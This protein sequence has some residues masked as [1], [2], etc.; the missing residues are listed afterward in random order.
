MEACR[1]DDELRLEIESLLEPS[2]PADPVPKDASPEPGAAPATG[3]SPLLTAGMRIGPYQIENKLG[4]GGMGEVYRARDVRLARYVAIKVLRHEIADTAARR[5]RFES[6]ARAVA[7]LTHPN[8]V[9]I[10]DFGELNGKPYAVSELIEGQSLRALLRRGPLAVRKVIDIAVQIADGLAAA[11][12]LGITHRDLKPENIMITGDGRVK[13]LDFGLALTVNRASDAASE[14]STTLTTKMTDPGTILGTANYMSPEQARGDVVDY[15]SDQFSFAVVVYELTTRR[16]PFARSSTVETLAAIVRDEPAPIE[17]RIPAPLSWIIDRC[18]S[19]EP[20]QRYESTRDLYEELRS[21]RDHL[22][23]AYTSSEVL[24][25]IPRNVKTSRIWK[26]AGAAGIIISF[27]AL[28]AAVLLAM[29]DTGTELARYRY[30]PL[31]IDAKQQ[32]DPIWSPDGKAIA[33]RT[34]FH[35][36]NHIFVRYVA[37]P[38]ARDLGI[39]R[40][41]AEPRRWSNDS[42]RIFLFATTD[43]SK[44][45]N[46]KSGFYSVSALGGDPTLI[47]DMP[48]GTAAADFSPDVGQIV[49]FCRCGEN[50]LG[51]SFSSPPGSPWHRYK[52]EPFATTTA[53]NGSELRFAPDGKQIPFILYGCQVGTG[54]LAPAIPSRNR[55]TASHAHAGTKR[56]STGRG[57]VAAG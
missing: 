31:A 22:S 29:R 41:N 6:E 5:G 34:V 23:E 49:A 28:S 47:M 46:S 54:S 20:K 1:G 36:E 11:H 53:Y 24:G 39:H 35:G 37:S 42:R 12:A 14:N 44:S 19:K 21:L 32:D 25:N 45:Q 40:R 16:H 27:L 48:E 10:F 2:S 15:R 8:I 4:F 7:S 13:I 33:Y 55:P 18:L 52:P 26:L 38:L 57:L 17:E 56:K 3:N 30:T 50:K 51:V 43:D 9:S